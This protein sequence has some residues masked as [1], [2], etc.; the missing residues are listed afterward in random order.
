MGKLRHVTSGGDYRRE[1]LTEDGRH[2]RKESQDIAPAI[3][4]VKD[5]SEMMTHATRANNPMGRQYLGSIPKTM[6]IDWLTARGY[7][8]DEWARN[9][10][11]TR[12]PAGSDPVAHA[13]LDGGVRSEFLRWYFSR[14]HS[15]LHNQH[16]TSKKKSSSIY[17][18][19]A[20]ADIRRTEIGDSQLD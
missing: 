18:G 5:H 16:V 15:K 17:V 13:T 1:F 7:T 14:D 4:R 12:C 20:D 3:Q 6:L 10:G 19:G 11:G 8:M 2:F 9:D